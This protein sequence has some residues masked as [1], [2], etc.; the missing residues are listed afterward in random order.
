AVLD[1]RIPINLAFTGVTGDR[2]LPNPMAVDLVSDSLP[3]EL[4][5]SF[6]DIVSNTKGLVAGKMSMRGTLRRPSLSGGFF[7]NKGQV[8]LNSTG[9]TIA[10]M[11]GTV[12][13]LN[14][15]VYVDSIVG[16]ARGPIR[17]R[18][19]LA[20]GDWREPSFNL[21]MITEAAEVLNNEYGKLRV[22]AAVALTGPFRN[23]YLSGQVDITEGV[24]NAPEPTGRHTIGAGDPALFNV[25]DTAIMS[26]RE[27]FPAHSPLL[28]NLRVEVA[29]NVHHNTW[30]RNREANVE[31][32]T[33]YP[34]M[35]R[36]EQ[37]ALA[38]TGVVTT[39]R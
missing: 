9:A 28:R 19:T 20:V 37:E 35:V 26:D 21:Y 33:D 22:D 6:T 12:R 38:L 5:P 36:V 14:D 2:L 16:S 10:E 24:I 18:G 1:G 17:L 30:V 29:L 25:L 3:V 8:T 23:A 34:M 11:V 27:L 7:I 4:I 31:V 13:M 32:Y 39:D 15:T